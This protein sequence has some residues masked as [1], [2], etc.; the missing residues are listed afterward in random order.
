MLPF[1]LSGDFFHNS[2]TGKGVL[3]RASGT[4]AEGLEAE[5]PGS[6]QGTAPHPYRLLAPHQLPPACLCLCELAPGLVIIVL[7]H[8]HDQ[9]SP[10]G[11]KPAWQPSVA[12]WP[13]VYGECLPEKVQAQ[14]GKDPEGVTALSKG[15]WDTDTGYLEAQRPAA[16]SPGCFLKDFKLQM[17]GYPP[18]GFLEGNFQLSGQQSPSATMPV[19]K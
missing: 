10:G 12:S 7:H 16:K 6:L 5:D 17:R 15:V 14:P 19:P 8:S 4:R 18:R 9:I 1:A 13:I 2:T 3:P 11:V